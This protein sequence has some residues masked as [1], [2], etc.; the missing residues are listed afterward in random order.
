MRDEDVAGTE[1]SEDLARLP[2]AVP[3]EMLGRA[4]PEHAADD[5]RCLNDVDL[6]GGNASRRAPMTA[7]I[8]RGTSTSP[9]SAASSQRP[10]AAAR[11]GALLDE[12]AE[13][14]LPEERVSLAALDERARQLRWGVR[15]EQLPDERLS[16]ARGQR[17]EGDRHGIPLAPAPRGSPLH[18]LGA[19]E[20]EDEHRCLGPVGEM[21]DEVE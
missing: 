16:L 10:A 11:R 18:E 9:G 21:V 17:F 19:C 8:D 7:R 13:D 14:L 1:A 20:R 6:V 12:H 2:P 15:A 3:A 5:G 4:D